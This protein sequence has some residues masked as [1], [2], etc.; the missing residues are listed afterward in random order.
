MTP[1]YA[2]SGTLLLSLIRYN[3]LLRGRSRLSTWGS[4]V[5]CH[6]VTRVTCLLCLCLE[7]CS[8]RVPFASVLLLKG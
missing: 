1:N 4:V 8:I 3:T 2:P 7:F 6:L 5:E